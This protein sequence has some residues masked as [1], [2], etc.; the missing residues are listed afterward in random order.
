MSEYTFINKYG[1]WGLVIG[2][3]EGLGEAYTLSLAQRN[4][5]IIMVDNQHEKLNSLADKIENDFGVKTIQLHLDLCN[6]QAVTPIMDQVEQL[7]CRLMIY[8]AAF[9]IIRPFSEI[10]DSELD[11][12]IETNVRSQIKLIHRFVNNLTKKEQSGGII[13]MSSLAGLIGTQLVAPYAATKAFTWNFAEALHHELR[14]FNI[15]VMSCLAGAT[16]TPTY[17]RDNPRYG[18]LKPVVMNP[19]AVA[20]KAIKKLG[21]TVLF[22][23]GFS[24]RINYFILMRL[25]PRSM[26]SNL[27]NK[28]MFA[29]YKH[30]VE[31]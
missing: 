3:A 16:A 24:N 29:M 31:S 27:V 7:D 6:E 2:A 20:E 11:K 1:S 17:L 5:N 25:L 15:D 21:K 18:F 23:P 28:T 13:L 14:S 22:I 8:N 9:S 4:V 12:F 10:T 30:K 26:A 19:F